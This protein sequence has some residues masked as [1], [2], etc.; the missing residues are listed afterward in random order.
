ML[1]RQHLPTFH[2]IFEEE[3]IHI[4]DS[5][6]VRVLGAQDANFLYQVIYHLVHVIGEDGDVTRAHDELPEHAAHLQ[7]I[8]SLSGKKKQEMGDKVNFRH[9]RELSYNNIAHSQT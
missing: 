8:L 5:R 7:P 3:V 9:S 2:G 1:H 4:E 6:A